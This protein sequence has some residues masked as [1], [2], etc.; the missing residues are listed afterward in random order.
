M[1][2]YR[3]V[4]AVYNNIAVVYHGDNDYKLFTNERFRPGAGDF[5]GSGLYTVYDL[6]NSATLKGNYGKY[7]IK[8]AVKLDHVLNLDA[9]LYTFQQQIDKSKIVFD[10][11]LEKHNR[12]KEIIFSAM[13]DTTDGYLSSKQFLDLVTYIPN[14]S[15]YYD[16]VIYTG[17]RDGKCLVI[18]NMKRYYPL[19]YTEDK[20]KTWKKLDSG[21]DFMKDQRKTYYLAKDSPKREKKQIWQHFINSAKAGNY[22]KVK[23][24][25]DKEVNVHAGGESALRLATENGHL[26]VVKLLVEYGADIHYFQD[27]CLA[28]ASEGGHLELV[29]FFLE[30][31]TFTQSKNSAFILS[32]SNEH[33][34]IVKL[35]LENG[36]DVHF[37][38]DYALVT[39]SER[40]HTEIVKLLLKFGADVHAQNNFALR[41]ASENGY[42]KVV[43]L[44]LKHGADAQERNN[45][46]LL[47]ASKKGYVDIINSFL[48]YGLGTNKDSALVRAS[49][50]GNM[51][52]VRLL[53]SY[54]ADPTAFNNLAIK[55]ADAMGQTNIVNV[56]KKA[57]ASLD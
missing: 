12:M 18:Y 40:G 26:E 57:G 56:L 16:G 46:L 15:D 19:S 34:D 52:V 4:E 22:K 36:A 33:T 25:L 44:L 8:L 43:K 9:P 37:S 11:S 42:S 55:S 53:L 51:G 54:G 7:I 6:K 28:I 21:T 45:E 32:A 49:E 50:Y 31:T 20:G 13:K 14:L 39:A 2:K 23:S 29:K 38:Q 30:H 1:K 24:L 41:K 47:K 3:L 5:Y 48:A 17:H 35:L 27:E 10:P